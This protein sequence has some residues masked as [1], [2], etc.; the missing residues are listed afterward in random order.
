MDIKPD[1]EER[2][3]DADDSGEAQASDADLED[4]DQKEK[5]AHA[6]DK[7]SSFKEDNA[8]VDTKP[9]PD[10]GV[11]DHPETKE[12]MSSLKDWSDLSFLEKLDSIHT[13]M[14][15]HFQNPLRFRQTMRSDDEE[16]SWVRNFSPCQYLFLIF[17]LSALSPLV[18]MRNSMHIGT[19]GVSGEPL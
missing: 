6:Q 1:I 10:T 3:T 7:L 14:E 11:V 15:W 13:V 19:S 12:G 8:E 16:A 5:M 9:T 17:F 2:P 18:M 4:K